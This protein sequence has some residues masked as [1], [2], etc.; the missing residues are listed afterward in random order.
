[1]K[2]LLR[3]R[4]RTLAKHPKT[5]G[6]SR[7]RVL[8]GIG[9][10]ALA[11]PFLESFAFDGEVQAQEERPIYSL[12]MRQGNGVQQ[13][14]N[15]EPDRFWPSSHGAI[16]RSS[17]MND[18]DRAVS[19]LADWA[20]RLL[21][22]SGTRYG[23]SH[24]DCGHSSGL[25]QCLTAQ[26]HTGGSSN[27]THALGISV[28]TRIAEAL[29]PGTPPLN[30]VAARVNTFLGPNLSYVASQQRRS[31][32]PNPF[33]IYT[34]LFANNDAEVINQLVVQRNSVNDLVREEMQWLLARDLSLG[35]RN[36]LDQH[37]SYIRDLEERMACNGL[38]Q[39]A[40]GQLETVRDDPEGE[41][42][43]DLVVDLHSRLIALAFACDLHRTCCFQI[44]T[45]ND[46]TKYYIDGQQLPYSFHWISHRRESDGS[47]GPEIANADVLHHQVD[48]KF[49][50]YFRNLIG[51]LDELSTVA[52]NNLLDDS[53]T[54]WLNDLSNGPPHS[55]DNLPYIIAGSGGGFL[56]QGRYV[57]AGGVTHNKFL[58]TVLSAVGVRKGN[59]D[60][61]DDFGD[62]SLERGL[63]PEMMV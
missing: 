18:S 35:D 54:I 6:P 34:D 63:I 4:S 21:M 10:V 57:D 52:G 41:S 17:L 60:Y 11:L 12:F 27:D 39:S 61:V 19:E 55:G 24:R 40:I 26:N 20:D 36:R 48:R 43:R 2:K 25:A 62:G 49:A 29:T 15:E 59:G 23:F 46:S 56:R 50:G 51:Y 5:S 14:W 45:G 38:D 42:N 30:V 1:M 9:G 58:N 53:V 22:V 16:S 32:E 37:F 13:G 44:G 8:R 31:A 7:R 47:D 33:N 28:D 3:R